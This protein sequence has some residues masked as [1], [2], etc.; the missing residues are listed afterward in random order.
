MVFEP[1][2]ISKAAFSFKSVQTVFDIRGIL[3]PTLLTVVNH[4]EAGF[5][6]PL[7]NLENRLASARLQGL[8][9]VAA[10]LFPG[11]QDGLLLGRSGEAAGMRG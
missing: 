5:R 7:D 9:V 11:S 1:V 4:I 6:L 8:G 10:L 3:R 2:P